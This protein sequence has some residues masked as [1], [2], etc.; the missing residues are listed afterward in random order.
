[1][2]FCFVE[3]GKDIN[4][5][6]VKMKDKI[7]TGILNIFESFQKAIRFLIKVWLPLVLKP[8]SFLLIVL[9]IFLIQFVESKN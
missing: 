7:K 6:M 1:M 3:I 4:Y 2:G 5:S 8:Q 9:G